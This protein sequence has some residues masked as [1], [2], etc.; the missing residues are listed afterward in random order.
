[1]TAST[2][3]VPRVPARPKT[4][5]RLSG[6]A[7]APTGIAG[8]DEI[9]GG[10]LPRGRTSLVCG[11]PGCGKTLFALEFLVHGAAEM[12]EPGVFVSFEEPKKDLVENVAS[13]G[14]DLADLVERKLLVIDQVVLDRAAIVEAG[15]FDLE[16]LFIRLGYAIKSIG[17]KRVALDTLESLFS[18]LPNPM[19][20]RAE[21]RRLFHW[22]KD[23]GVTAVLT[24]EKGE[25][26]LTRE[27]L[28]EYVSDCVIVLDHRVLHDVTTRRLRI[29]KYRGSAHQTNEFP[30]IIDASGFMVVPITGSSL[31]KPA[32]RERISTG[33]PALDELLGGKGFYRESSILVSGTAGTGK[34]TLAAQFVAAACE[35]GERAIYFSFE[36]APD[37]LV[38]DMLSVGIDLGR[39][40]KEGLLRMVS[41]RASALGLEMHAAMVARHVREFKPTVAALDPVSVFD[42]VADARE[43]KNTV[44]L[45]SD[46]LRREGVTTMMTYLSSGGSVM[47][48]TGGTLSS[49]ADAWLLLR[50]VE[51]DG[52][53]NRLVYALK[54]RGIAHS[55]QL[56]EFLLTDHGIEL[57]P[58]YIG[59]EGVLTGSARASREAKEEAEVEATSEAVV[60]RRAEIAR[61]RLALDERIRAMRAELAAQESEIERDI[62]GAE[63]VAGKLLETRVG[64]ATRRGPE[65]TRPGVGKR[66][67]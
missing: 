13:L 3:P 40:V 31:D 10:G 56:R 50:D 58:P 32:T 22:L 29:A 18:G 26:T 19:L 39:Y 11:G 28:E 1:M 64:M 42:T 4:A 5:A 51:I 35:R 44:V 41:S 17:A 46:M 49:V 43:A 60:R 20:V 8:F 21:I 54:A 45:I 66:V 61:N 6:I 59:A 23:Q 47:E 2:V 25:D 55:N 57:R 38:R 34:S 53:R 12:G 7:K 24:A 62:H 16:G 65:P 52:E 37:T 33:V 48:T 27:G 63:A 9:A 30:F 67:P 36:E 15:E 14:F